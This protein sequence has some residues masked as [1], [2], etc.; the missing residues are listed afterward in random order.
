VPDESPGDP[1]ARVESL[2]D[3]GT[4]GPYVPLT[5]EITVIG[6]SVY[7]VEGNARDV[8]RMILDAA[9]SSI[10]QFAW[11]VEVDSAARI[12]VNPAHVV[13]LRALDA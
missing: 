13:A 7:R 6:G 12:A 2:V 1:A 4:A 10:M 8:E 11:L 3:A 5:T 9:R